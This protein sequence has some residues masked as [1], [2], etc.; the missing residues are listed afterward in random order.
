MVFGEGVGKVVL[1]EHLCRHQ[2]GVFW[3]GTA[4]TGH[5]TPG[6]MGETGDNCGFGS[7][8]WDEII[9]AKGVKTEARAVADRF[10]FFELFFH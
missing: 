5:C 9:V 6:T 1:L 3:H 10:H 4:G 8:M 7:E 2:V